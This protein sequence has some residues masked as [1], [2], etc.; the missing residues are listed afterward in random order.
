MTRRGS[1]R[2]RASSRRPTSPPW[3]APSRID[4]GRV[5]ER[6]NGHPSG[7]QQGADRAPPPPAWPVVA[8]ASLN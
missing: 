1:A 8:K 4:A 3:A 2:P 5:R 6:L 7:V